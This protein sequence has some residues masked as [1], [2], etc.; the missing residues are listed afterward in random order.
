VTAETRH[1]RH[2]GE[3]LTLDHW[4]LSDGSTRSGWVGGDGWGVLCGVLC[5][6]NYEAHWPDGATSEHEPS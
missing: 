6:R 5:R 3:L 1:C 4:T 2:C